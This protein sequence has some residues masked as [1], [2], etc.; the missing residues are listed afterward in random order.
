MHKRS[1]LKKKINNSIYVKNFEFNS[2]GVI[3]TVPVK[4]IG[5]PNS[6]L[7]TKSIL[8]SYYAKVL[9]PAFHFPLKF[10]YF[11]F[12]QVAVI[13]FKKYYNFLGVIKII[14]KLFNKQFLNSKF[15]F[16]SNKLFV[17]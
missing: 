1:F 13:F 16:R 10:Y 14:H 17:I 6:I 15:F 5:S 4:S 7:F 2:F 12:F 3:L 9:T 8:K 11:K